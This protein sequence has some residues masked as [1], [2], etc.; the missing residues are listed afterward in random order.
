MNRLI[1]LVLCFCL[2][3]GSVVFSYGADISTG[4]AI[5][6]ASPSDSKAP[7]GQQVYI[8]ENGTYY[9]YN[10]SIVTSANMLAASF[11]DFF[12]RLMY[13]IATSIKSL[14]TTGVSYYYSP[15]TTDGWN[16]VNFSVGTSSW[17][18]AVNTQISEFERE[19]IKRFA[20]LESYLQNGITTTLGSPL[21]PYFMPDPNS[22]NYT[23]SGF[24]QYT[25]YSADK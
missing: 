11:G 2:V 6:K 4:A 15:T 23:G 10:G 18:T 7:A 5:T 22:F 25:T 9:Y 3:F 17:L 14:T 24:T 8:S 20:V 19:Y 1:S 12:S 16:N 21:I 13:S